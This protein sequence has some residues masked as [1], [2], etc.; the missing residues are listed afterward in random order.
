LNFN[1]TLSKTTEI[2]ATVAVEFLQ[3]D[4]M[5]YFEKFSINEPSV[6]KT[7]TVDLESDRSYIL[8]VSRHEQELYQTDKLVH[9]S[10][11]VIDSIVIDDFWTIDSKNHWSKTVYDSAYIKHLKD[12]SVTWELSKHLHNNILFFNGSLDY[13]IKTPIRSMF[14]Q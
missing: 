6:K 9:D 8:K 4:Y 14:F 13:N 3:D 1:L 12:K 2:S 7:F 10:H 5:L 11:L